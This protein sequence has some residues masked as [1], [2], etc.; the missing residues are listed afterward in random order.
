MPSIAPARALTLTF[1]T[2]IS[3]SL[4]DKAEKNQKEGPVATWEYLTT[5][6]MIRNTAAILNNWG[7]EGWELVQIVTGPEGGIVA[8]L[9]RPLAGSPESMD[10]R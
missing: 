5:P 3:S 10:A 1:G 2:N 8:Y 6:L 4:N 9:K 7:A